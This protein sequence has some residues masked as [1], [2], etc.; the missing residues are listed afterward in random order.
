MKTNTQAIGDQNEQETPAGA[1]ILRKRFVKNP[2]VTTTSP[3]SHAMT[4][5]DFSCL[6]KKK[7]Q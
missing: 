5:I 3:I 2:V 6:T 7:K 4:D 1:T